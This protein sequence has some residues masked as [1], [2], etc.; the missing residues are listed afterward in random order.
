MVSARSNTS[1]KNTAKFLFGAA[2]ACLISLGGNANAAMVQ[3]GL[4]QSYT[5]NI[6]P[7]GPAPWLTATF[8]DYDTGPFSGRVTLTLQAT[9]LINSEFVR[10][11]MFNLNPSLNA[12]NLNFQVLSTTG[13]FANPTFATGNDSLIA[14]GG[15]RFDLAVNFAVAPP[16]QRFGAGDAVTILIGSSQ[17]ALTVA[18]FMYFASNNSGTFLTA[19]HILG[20][21]ANAEESAWISAIP[22]WNSF[23]PVIGLIV[24]VVS[25]QFLRRRKLAN[26]SV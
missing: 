22:E 15:L 18:D 6:T 1:M 16:G 4:D 17:G 25:T 14:G 24:A 8:Q 20:I 11:W 12:S 2:A 10:T 21:G 13:Q 9:N 5:S 7:G 19:A 3:I 26:A 23:F